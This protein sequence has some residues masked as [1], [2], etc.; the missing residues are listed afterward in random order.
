M[1]IRVAF[2][3]GACGA[4]A[5]AWTDEWWRGG[6]PVEDWKFG[7][8]DAERRPKPAARAVSAAFANAPFSRDQEL[9]WPRVSVVVCAYNAAETL[10]DNLHSL[11]QLTYPNYEV[12]LVN[13]GSKDRTSEIG[14]A[15]PRVRV[16]DTL[17]QGLSA[18]RNVGLAEATGEIVA[19][20]DA[21][22]R[23][24]RDWL[25][26]L[27]QPFLAIGCRRL[28]RTQRGSRRR[29][30][31]RAVHRACPR[32]SDA[33]AARRSDRGARPR[34]QHGVPPRRAA[35]DRRIQSGVSPRRRRCGRVLAAAGA[36]LENRLRGGRPGLAP[37][38]ELRS[39]RTGRSRSA[40][41]R[42]KPG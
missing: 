14:R 5:F 3:E 42:A 25:T 36:G 34:L 29:P 18:A 1:H 31:D 20:T 38:P 33:R 12:I 11:D 32:W 28:R 23:V 8:V 35:R 10:E 27:V 30:T 19:Y 16:I 6:H 39:R 17:N 7:L 40:T 37:P 13:D 2:E 9:T 26:F 24:D 41:A 4:V 15:H 22:T 21:D